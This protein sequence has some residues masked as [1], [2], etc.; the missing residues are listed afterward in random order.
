MGTLF[1]GIMVL[2]INQILVSINSFNSVTLETYINRHFIW[3][4]QLRNKSNMP[5]LA[6]Q[7]VN[8]D[9]FRDIRV[10]KTTQISFCIISLNPVTLKT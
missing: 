8:G 4:N 3:Q 6:E 9:P 10:P 7:G 2:R 1:I 5:V